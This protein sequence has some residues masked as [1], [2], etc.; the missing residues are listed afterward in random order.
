LNEQYLNSDNSFVSHRIIELCNNAN[1]SPK[2]QTLFQKTIEYEE[3]KY[4]G[5]SALYYY[6]SRVFNNTLLV[7]KL[8]SRSCQLF[9]LKDFEENRGKMAVEEY[10]KSHP[11]FEFGGRRIQCLDE[12][13]MAGARYGF[14]LHNESNPDTYKSEEIQVSVLGYGNVGMGPF[15]NVT[16]K[17]LESFRF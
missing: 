1:R 11:P 6:D 17:E 15:V 5:E 12:T 16:T 14:Q 9:D 4:F 10:R 7:S 8:K 13:G 2:T 3:L